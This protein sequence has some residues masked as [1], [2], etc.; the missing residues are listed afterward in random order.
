MTEQQKRAT[1]SR[2]FFARYLTQP[3]A[4]ARKPQVCINAARSP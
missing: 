1:Q 2:P 3:S 4:C